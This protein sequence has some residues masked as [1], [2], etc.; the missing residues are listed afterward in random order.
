MTHFR[1]LAVVMAER[2]GVVNL[3]LAAEISSDASRMTMLYK[4]AEGP[5]T[6]QFYNLTLA[7]LVDLPP[8]VLNVAQDVSEK[9][10]ETAARRHGNSGALTIAKKRNLILT[11]REQL[12]QARNG[13]Y[14]GE[15]LRKWLK[16]LQ[17]DF[18]L[19][20]ASI[21]DELDDAFSN[22]EQDDIIEDYQ[23]DDS[24]EGSQNATGL[25]DD[26]SSTIFTEQF[27]SYDTAARQTAPSLAGEGSIT[28]NSSQEIPETSP[29]PESIG[30]F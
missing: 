21:D 3:H 10:N 19:Q 7:K 16:K 30:L 23:D 18:L 26:S 27:E 17:D 8:D 1:D 13:A 22:T 2:S 5:V 25:T 28:I 24:Q 15:S 9:L 6:T 14:E 11:L 12:Y 20:M 29:V 4:I